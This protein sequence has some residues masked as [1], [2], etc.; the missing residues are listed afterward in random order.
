V[1]DIYA[2]TKKFPKDE[3]F[4]LITQIRSSSTSILANLAEGFGKYTY[5]DKAGK[6]VIARGECTETEA[7]LHIAASLNFVSSSGIEPIL[8]RT[9]HVGRLLLGLI[10]SMRKQSKN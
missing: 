4:E 2:I 8:K 6:Y 9:Q 1:N 5:A 10:F 3:R 7:F